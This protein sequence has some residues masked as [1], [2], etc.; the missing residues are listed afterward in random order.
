[1]CN[2]PILYLSAIITLVLSTTGFAKN[3][4]PKPTFPEQALGKKVQGE[5][6]LEVLGSKLPEVAAWYGMAPKDFAKLL[7]TDRTA[8]LDKTGRLYYNDDKPEPTG[9]QAEQNTTTPSA[10]PFPL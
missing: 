1:M 3:P 4:P 8:W 5:K 6:A 2:S 10:A 9:E 7:K